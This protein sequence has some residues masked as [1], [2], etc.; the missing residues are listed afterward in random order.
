MSRSGRPW[1]WGI[2][3][4]A[5]CSVPSVDE[6]LGERETRLVI[7]YTSGFDK[8]CFRVVAQDAE[9]PSSREERLIAPRPDRNGEPGGPF[10]SVEGLRKE[11][12]RGRIQVSVT[13]HEQA[14][15][16]SGAQIGSAQTLV[17]ELAKDAIELSFATPDADGDGFVDLVS[18][19]SDCNDSPSIGARINPGMAE[20]CDDLDNDCDGIQDEGLAVE[21]LFTDRDGDGYG[22]GA[23]LIRCRPATGFATRGGDC[24]DDDAALAPG[25]AELCDERDNNCDGVVDE[26]FSGKGMACA[27]SCNGVLACG[28]DKRT[29]VC[30]KSDPGKYYPDQDGDGQGAV[31]STA[32]EACAGTTPPMGYVLGNNTDCDDTDANVK[33]GAPEVCDAIDNNCSGDETDGPSCG[34]LLPVTDGAVGDVGR[35]WRTVS[36]GATGY[37]VWLAGVGGSLVVKKAAGQAFVD[38]SPDAT[39]R[40]CGSDD[41]YASWVDS[42]GNVYLAGQHGRLAKH[43]GVEC[44][45]EGLAE[46][47]FSLVGLVG[48]ESGALVTVYAVDGG[49]R[50]YK[51]VPG[52]TPTLLATGSNGDTSSGLH[53]WNG[54]RL[55]VTA[56]SSL[57]GTPRIW[58]YDPT[59]AGSPAQHAFTRAPSTGS[60]DA[61]AMGSA[62]TATAVGSLGRAWRWDGNVTWGLAP[63]SGVTV[64]FS[65]VVM[66]A[67]GDSY[68]VDKS[69]AGQVHR[70]TPHG[71]AK[72][73]KL[74][75]LA[76]KPLYDI[77]MAGPGD[78][79]LV[80]DDGRVWHYPEP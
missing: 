70:L 39:T 65:S 79:W 77:A 61:I 45:A 55:L 51:W 19:G 38:F 75:A 31:G 49:G 25:L 74:T 7:H 63:A 72:Q 22:A 35:D 3:L 46:V 71:W 66:L 47:N 58:S 13:A 21:E 5:G 1:L 17:L 69:P 2:L 11:G 14:C 16:Q 43:S 57:A 67:N 12:W 73:P 52:S 68:I 44:V 62:L 80:G 34:R 33:V 64:N 23:A 37:P 8:G 30:S 53:G 48:F 24:D 56:T 42:G 4:L 59:G 32:V 50:L 18:D 28:P 54:N 40:N 29:L 78:F 41:W 76:N 9:N 60:L 15:D 20:V 26:G 10:V 36:V 6:L 27:G